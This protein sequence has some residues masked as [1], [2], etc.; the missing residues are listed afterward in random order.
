VI[1]FSNHIRGLVLVPVL[2]PSLS[3]LLHSV[4][5]LAE[6]V[7]KVAVNSIE[8][9]QEGQGPE[10]MI[11]EAIRVEVPQ[12]AWMV[13]M[14]HPASWMQEVFSLVVSNV[15]AIGLSSDPLVVRSI[16]LSGGVLLTWRL[17]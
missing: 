5:E 7:I 2:E 16:C 1:S 3:C 8:G 9:R 10:V 4:F 14:H 11:P 17:S 6:H 13:V 12:V 15:S